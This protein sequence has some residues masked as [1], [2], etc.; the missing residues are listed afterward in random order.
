VEGIAGLVCIWEYLLPLSWENQS[1]GGCGCL[2]AVS[3]ACPERLANTAARHLAS[4][5]N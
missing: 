1:G 4:R 2:F 3:T 5:S